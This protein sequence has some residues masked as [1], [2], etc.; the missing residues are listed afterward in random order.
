MWIF[1]LVILVYFIRYYSWNLKPEM[2]SNSH[3]LE[4]LTSAKQSLA[5]N[6]STVFFC[7]LITSQCIL[8]KFLVP[9]IILVSKPIKKDV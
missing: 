4:L 9:K 6:F 7:K 8:I 1:M 2:S 5:L 3:N